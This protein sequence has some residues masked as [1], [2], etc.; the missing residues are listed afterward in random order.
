MIEKLE[1][2]LAVARERNFRRAAEA[3]GVAQPT[4]SAGIKSL[5]QA[6]G[7]LLIRRSSR[8]QGLT[9]EGERVLEW[10][11]RLAG[12]ARAMRQEVQAMRHGLT[13]ELRLGVIPTALPY[14]PAITRPY[15]R[16]HSGVRIT[17]L[18]RSSNEILQ[19]L[20]GLQLDAGLT[21]LEN[22]VLGRLRSIP[23][24]VERYNLLTGAASPMA[25]RHS[26]SWA[27]VG[28][29]PLCLF[30]PDMQN[31]RI[32]DRLLRPPG[33]PTRPCTV[34][35]DSTIALLAHVRD[36]ELSTVVSEQVASLLAGAEPFRA[37]PIADAEAAFLVGL[38]VPDHQPL[39]P[40]LRALVEV[41]G[42]LSIPRHR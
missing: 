5:E 31:R 24:Y 3:C 35:S 20:D 19:Q 41:A 34:E 4:L 23:L 36:G 7:V 6:L 9:P 21:Y 28:A 40:I 11:R 26:V 1:F 37:I 22:E 18:P 25:G 13:G 38:V 27:E 10:A 15:R 42:R 32:L 16:R 33:A 8:F 17:V 29:L 30:T 14:T 2:L 12:D 39:P